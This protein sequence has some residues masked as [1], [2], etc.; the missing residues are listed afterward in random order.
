LTKTIRIGTRG[1]QLALTQTNWV[2]ARLKELR[3]DTPVTIEIV[4][5]TGDRIQDRPIEDLGVEGAFTKE[6]ELALQESRVDAVVHSLKDL[7]TQLAAGTVV[8]AVPEREDPRDAFVGRTVPLLA[9]LPR[10]ALVGTS[11]LRRLAQVLA[12]RPDVRAEAIRGNVDTRLRKLRESEK[13][14]GIILAAAGL[15]RLGL[16]HVITDYFELDRWLPAPGQ[17]ALGIAARAGDAETLEALGALDHWPT[18]QA[19]TAERRMLARLQGGCSIPVGAWARIE[20]RELVL[21]GLVASLDGL[22]VLREKIRGDAGQ[23]ESL[24]EE[25]GD[26]LLAQGGIEILS[27]YR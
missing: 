26:I 27:Q 23:P 1:S 24:G 2:M 13:M 12:W 5:T 19:V 6:L 17:G 7:P 8:A 21:E 3:P 25:L 18:R 22:Q 16:A 20:N 10:A 14:D 4:K 9:D 15:R 11:S